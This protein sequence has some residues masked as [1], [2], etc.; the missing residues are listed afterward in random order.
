MTTDSIWQTTSKSIENMFP[1]HI[2]SHN[3]KELPLQVQ[4]IEHI[5]TD[6]DSHTP[7]IIVGSIVWVSW[8]ESD[9]IFSAIVE[10]IKQ[11]FVNI[12]FISAGKKR[13][14]TYSLDYFG[15]PKQSVECRIYDL[16]QLDLEPGHSV[17]LKHSLTK[18]TKSFK[19]ISI[20]PRCFRIWTG[21]DFQLETVGSCFLSQR[22]LLQNQYISKL[23]QLF[24]NYMA[25]IYFTPDGMIETKSL[26]KSFSDA[27]NDFRDRGGLT[28]D[29]ENSCQSHHCR[30]CITN[31]PSNGDVYKTALAEKRSIISFEW[32]NTC[33]RNVS[34]F[35]VSFLEQVTTRIFVSISKLAHRSFIFLKIVYSFCN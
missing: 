11:D 20:L 3:S 23:D 19:I 10:S 18:N 1:S 22:L 5:A 32:I 13:F 21:S 6:Y 15:L 28:Q 17:L 33:V 27:I 34:I 9:D 12:S 25:L 26:P 2:R 4:K 16:H 7:K 31:Q 29:F 24:S 14:L 30:I 8:N 35:D